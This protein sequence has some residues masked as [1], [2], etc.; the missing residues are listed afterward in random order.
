MSHTWERQNNITK[1]WQKDMQIRSCRFWVEV[2]RA[3][4]GWAETGL[5]TWANLSMTMMHFASVL[6][7]IIILDVTG[8]KWMRADL[9]LGGQRM[10]GVA[11]PQTDQDGVNLRTF[12]DSAT[13]VWE[14]AT[15][16]AN[17][18]AGNV[19]TNH[20]NILN[21]DIRTKTK[22]FQIFK[23]MIIKLSDWL[24]QQ[25]LLMAWTKEHWMLQ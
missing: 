16:A 19:I 10:R 23:W 13:S 21:R 20:A 3:S 1:Q 25:H 24:M 18:A 9:S 8:A 6:Q 5:D 12:Q 17:T 14:Q 15:A 2:C 22:W 4:L 11:N 7:T